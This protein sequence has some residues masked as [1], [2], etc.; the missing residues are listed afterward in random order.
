MYLAALI[1]M[2]YL[3]SY[4]FNANLKRWFRDQAARHAA[5]TGLST[6]S[7]NPP[8]GLQ[9]ALFPLLFSI[10]LSNT[11]A[12]ALWV[13]Q[14]GS[15]HGCE[16]LGTQCLTHLVLTHP[17]EFGLLCLSGVT[18]VTATVLVLQYGSIQL[19]QI[20][21][22]VGPLFTAG[23][24]YLAL[25]Q[26]TTGA[27]LACLAV[28]LAGTVLASWQE[29]SFC[30]A[31][32]SLMFIVNAT[33]TYRNVA[34]KRFLMLLPHV[35]ATTLAGALLALTSAVGLVLTTLLW[36][37]SLLISLHPFVPPHNIRSV[38]CGAQR[39]AMQRVG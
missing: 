7:P 1:L 31:A 5:A 23:W 37:S 6:P 20:A 28:T 39:V 32:A 24:A 19:V 30:L 14:T 33:L 12:T 26:G 38:V 9:D 16:L 22:S 17:W 15:R 36:G 2:W 35:D 18:G 10:F 13:L 4:L 25:N 29:P 34:T 11:A 3:F 8:L 27:R 21:R